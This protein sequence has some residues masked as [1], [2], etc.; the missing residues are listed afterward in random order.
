MHCG[1]TV[2]RVEGFVQVDGRT[3]TVEG[4]Q[5][6]TAFAGRP[7]AAHIAVVILALEGCRALRWNIM[8][9]DDGRGRVWRRVGVF[10]RPRNEAEAIPPP[11]VLIVEVELHDRERSRR[12]QGL[13]KH[14]REWFPTLSQKFQHWHLRNVEQHCAGIEHAA[15]GNLHLHRAAVGRRQS[16]HFCLK[17]D[18]G[19]LLS[20]ATQHRF[21]EGEVANVLSVSIGEL[22]HLIIP[23]FRIGIVNTGSQTQRLHRSCGDRRVDAPGHF[24]TP[25]HGLADLVGSKAIGASLHNQVLLRTLLSERVDAS[26]WPVAQLEDANLLASL[27]CLPRGESAADAGTHNCEVTAV[28]L[29]CI[30]ARA[31]CEGWGA[32][33]Q[34]C[35]QQ[36]LA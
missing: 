16:S 8:N 27:C 1:I 20:S 31:S 34:G 23:V 11:G 10:K 28:V 19:S 26:T 15:V 6:A 17:P 36:Q 2:P 35:S 22:P 4:L 14:R 12:I 30:Y 21:H 32:S 29:S 7:I 9:I 18:P 5:K 24:P 25:P 3:A 33:H 13:G